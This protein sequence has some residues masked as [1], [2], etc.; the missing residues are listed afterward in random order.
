MQ[1]CA[2]LTTLHLIRVP[3]SKLGLGVA[4]SHCKSLVE[5]QLWLPGVEV[6]AEA[7]IPSLT[8]LDMR[9]KLFPVKHSKLFVK[10]VKCT[11]RNNVDQSGMLL[12]QSY[13]QNRKTKGA[14]SKQSWGPWSAAKAHFN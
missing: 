9:S 8:S 10:S 1:S 2:R 12:S 13:L 7:G 4:L 6:P 11:A 3:V 14:A 5:L